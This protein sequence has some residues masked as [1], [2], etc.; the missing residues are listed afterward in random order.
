MKAQYS[1]NSGTIQLPGASYD[2]QNT[3]KK[4]IVLLPVK[5]NYVT[6]ISPEAKILL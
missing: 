2:P 1:I 6:S 3:P 5:N 4:M